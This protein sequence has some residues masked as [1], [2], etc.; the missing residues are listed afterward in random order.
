MA[1]ISQNAHF[2]PNFF[3]QKLKHTNRYFVNTLLKFVLGDFQASGII[4]KKPQRFPFFTFV[5]YLHFWRKLA[6]TRAM[7]NVSAKNLIVS[8]NTTIGA[9]VGQ[10]WALRQLL[11]L[12]Y[13]CLKFEARMLFFS[14]SPYLSR[15]N[16]RKMRKDEIATIS[17]KM[18]FLHSV[19]SV[20]LEIGYISTYQKFQRNLFGKVDPIWP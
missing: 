3:G 7:E 9:H 6:C 18:T 11:S 1:E 19:K 13:D 10:I 14:N 15:L 5:K 12:I 20:V 2:G 4:F 8:K 17:S 16:F